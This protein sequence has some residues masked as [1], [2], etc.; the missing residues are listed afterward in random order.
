M[1]HDATQRARFI[2]F[3]CHTAMRNRPRHRSAPRL[4]VVFP[5]WQGG[6]WS[7]RKTEGAERRVAPNKLHALAGVPR[8]LAKDA[9]PFGAPHG[10]FRLRVRSSTAAQLL[11]FRSITGRRT[12]A[13]YRLG[14]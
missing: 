12:V 3:T 9:A 14:S 4:A 1:S 6:P 13:T 2:R 11:H 7:P 8:P 5:P 10:A